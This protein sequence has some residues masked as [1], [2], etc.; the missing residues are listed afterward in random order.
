MVVRFYE[1]NADFHEGLARASQNRYLWHTIQEQNS[2]RRFLNYSWPSEFERVRESI[3]EHLEIL[4]AL[5][6]G[7]NKVASGLMTRHLEN[8][9]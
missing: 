2:L 8:A 1:V 9:Q 7:K 3:T 5:E 4:T 6:Q